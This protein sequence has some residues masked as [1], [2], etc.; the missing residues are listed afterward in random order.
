MVGNSVFLV[1]IQIKS[2]T[3]DAEI[4]IAVCLFPDF[5][6]QRPGN[7]SFGVQK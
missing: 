3:T 2:A 5:E 1:F 7:A 6:S 4:K